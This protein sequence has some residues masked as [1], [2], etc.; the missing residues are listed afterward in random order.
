MYFNLDVLYHTSKEVRR[1]KANARPSSKQ[2]RRD[3]YS[4]PLPTS[5]ALMINQLQGK[6]SNHVIR[7]D[8]QEPAQTTKPYQKKKASPTGLTNIPGF[9]AFP[10]SQQT[11]KQEKNTNRIVFPLPFRFPHSF[12]LTAT[13]H[14]SLKRKEGGRQWGW[15]LQGFHNC[16]TGPQA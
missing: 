4:H 9:L 15:V 5:A 13:T 8:D 16:A 2:Q 12:P 7:R 10:L 14:K 1:R 11:N 6:H 3:R